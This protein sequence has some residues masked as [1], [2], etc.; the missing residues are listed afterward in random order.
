MFYREDI[1]WKA[2]D[3]KTGLPK[4]GEVYVKYQNQIQ[5]YEFPKKNVA[6]FSMFSEWGITEWAVI[7][8]GEEPKLNHP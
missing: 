4:T 5:F 2:V 6:D 3:D 7:P 1:P 8:K